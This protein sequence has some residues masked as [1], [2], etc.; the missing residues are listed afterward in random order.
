M[1][2]EFSC[3]GFC[4]FEKWKKSFVLGRGGEGGGGWGGL[5]KNEYFP[6]WKG[7]L[8][9]ADV[10]GVH[11]PVNSG[12]LRDYSTGDSSPPFNGIGP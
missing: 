2:R 11:L 4:S 12:A 10:A 6:T 9:R 8:L 1:L 3:T 7:T 5:K